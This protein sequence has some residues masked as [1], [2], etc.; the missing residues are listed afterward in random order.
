MPARQNNLSQYKN[1][2]SFM[3]R[4]TLET[5]QVISENLSFIF[6]SNSGNIQRAISEALKDFDEVEHPFEII[7]NSS[8]SEFQRAGFYGAQLRLKRDLV[9]NANE[10]LRAILSSIDRSFFR[11]VFIK[12]VDIINNFL[13]SLSSAFGIAEALKELKDC[14][15]DSLP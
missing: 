11:S 15:R 1:D 12:W 3:L 2:V 5:F 6:G 7:Q 10:R 13:G 4:D 9:S 8:L 14:L